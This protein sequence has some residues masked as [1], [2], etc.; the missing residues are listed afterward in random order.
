M[1]R[2]LEQ[3]FFQRRHTNDQQVHAKVL[4]FIKCQGNAYQ[5]CSDMPPHTLRV[6]F[7]KVISIGKDMEKGKPLCN[8]YGNVKCCYGKHMKI[9]QKLKNRVIMQS[10][11]P[12]SGYIPK[13]NE[14]R[15]SKRYMHS[16]FIQA[17]FTIHKIEKQPKC[18]LVNK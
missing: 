7:T 12:T 1:G 9:P 10:N 2:R 8:I 11:N 14:N 6:T 17:L 3:T 13:R 18:S 5:N 16:M 15:I 4:N